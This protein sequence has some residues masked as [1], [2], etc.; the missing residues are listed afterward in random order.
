MELSISLFKPGATAAQCAKVHQTAIVNDLATLA[1]LIIQGT[2][3]SPAIF[4]DGMRSNENFQSTNLLVLD[5]DDGWPLATAIETFSDY[6]HIIA[7]TKSHGIEKKGKVADR[8]R[9]VLLLDRHV[10]TDRE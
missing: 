10:T 1:D 7:T 8:Y 3:W 4:K 5:I 2:P 9:V 6:A